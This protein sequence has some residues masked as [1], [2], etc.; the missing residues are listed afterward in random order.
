[1]ADPR[2][3]PVTRLRSRHRL[4]T[5]RRADRS[6]LTGSLIMDALVVIGA[7]IWW[8]SGHWQVA[9]AWAAAAL[10]AAVSSVWAH[11]QGPALDAKYE[12]WQRRGLPEPGA[13]AVIPGI[14]VVLFITARFGMGWTWTDAAFILSSTTVVCLAFEWRDAR[15]YRTFLAERPVR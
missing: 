7:A 2:S 3:E 1:M 8:L 4:F 15:R 9:V 12:K 6:R 5:Q 11:R 14:A 13:V 10:V